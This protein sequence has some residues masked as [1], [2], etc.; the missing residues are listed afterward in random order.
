M[1]TTSET[2]PVIYDFGEHNGKIPFSDKQEFISFLEKERDS[3]S[4]LKNIDSILFNIISNCIEKTISL[5]NRNELFNSKIIEIIASYNKSYNNTFR[6]YNEGILPLSS[7]PEFFAIEGIKK[8][9]P[10]KA[11]LAIRFLIGGEYLKLFSPEAF[12]AAHSMSHHLNQIPSIS[13]AIQENLKNLV[14]EYKQKIFEINTEG[15]EAIK[16]IRQTEE[17][18]KEYMKLGASIDYWKNKS[19]GHTIRVWICGILLILFGVFGGGWLLYS[20]WFLVNYVIGLNTSPSNPAYFIYATLAVSG[21]T[22]VFWIGRVLSRLYLSQYHLALD[23]GERATMIGTYLALIDQGA[24]T[25]A[26]RAIVLATLFR[27]T[28]DGIV[29]DDAAPDLSLTSILAKLGAKGT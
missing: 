13:E 23:V 3:Y 12:E 15:I 20:L 6:L 17:T 19:R 16:S 11:A 24:A 18:Y 7:K 25:E 22:I 1:S 21:T 26:E 9:N 28:E 14:S 2:E 10:K 29:K 4:W 8:D 27:P 5:V